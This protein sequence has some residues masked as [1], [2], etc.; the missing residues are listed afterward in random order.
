MNTND[1]DKLMKEIYGS[2]KT[3]TIDGNKITIE[4][5]NKSKVPDAETIISYLFISLLL[6]VLLLLFIGLIFK[7]KNSKNKNSDDIEMLQ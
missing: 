1:Y 6:I 7:N 4:I 2:D 3:I 5:N